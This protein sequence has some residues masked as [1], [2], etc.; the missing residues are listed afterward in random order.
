MR[1]ALR[2]QLDAIAWG[3]AL[4]TVAALAACDREPPLTSCQG[5]LAGLWRD[6]SAPGTERWAILE[7][8]GTSTR[9]EA[10]PLF[11][12]T[13]ATAAADAAAQRVSS[14]RSLDLIRSHTALWGHV[15]RWVM[16]GGQ[17]CLLRASAR[18]SGCRTD[19]RGDDVIDV[20]LGELP[21]PATDEELAACP[22]PSR[23]MAPARRWRREP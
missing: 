6:E 2:D 7:L 8:G 19:D 18:I 21:L 3:A 14:P 4:A 9:L 15:E 22:T 1:A 23:A 5:S 11:D 12:D 17:K 13:A 16:R 10:Y 20:Q